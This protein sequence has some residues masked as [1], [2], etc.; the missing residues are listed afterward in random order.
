MFQVRFS[1]NDE[2][3]PLWDDDDFR[4][5]RIGEWEERARDSSRFRAR[6]ANCS[7]VISPILST[8]HRLKIQ[9]MLQKLQ[10]IESRDSQVNKEA[11]EKVS[12]SR[13]GRRSVCVH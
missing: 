5:A 1:E 10:E 11:S 4:K 6:I 8:E 7:A 12:P 2:I 13:M 9:L 3:C